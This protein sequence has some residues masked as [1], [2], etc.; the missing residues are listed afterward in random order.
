LRSE[1]WFLAAF[2]VWTLVRAANPDLWHPIY[3]GEK[4]F[5]FGFLNAILRSPVLPP[6][7]PFFSGGIVNYYYYG[8]FLVA[9]P[10]KAI[11]I[12]PAVGFNLAIALL[13]ALTTTAVLALGREISG[14]WRWGLLAV[15]FLVGMGPLASIIKINEARGLTPVFQAL[16]TGLTGF[17]ERLGAWFWGPSRIIPYTINE[18]PLFAFLFADLHPHLIALPITL[19]AVACALELGRRRPDAMLLALGA[20]VL[21]ALAV[22]NSWDAPTYALVIGGT[23]VGRTWQRAR[24]RLRTP[25]IL[26]QVGV[27]ALLSLGMLI[28]GVVLYFPFFSH[29]QAMVGGIGF[30]EQ[31][32]RVVDWLL[33]FGPLLFVAISLLGVL[34]WQAAYRA[35]VRWRWAARGV[36][37]FVPLLPVVL[38]LSGWIGQDSDTGVALP[39]LLGVL[40][41]AGAGMAPSLRLRLRDWLPLWLITVG[42]LVALGV[43]L[44]FV[45]DHLAGSDFRRMNT[46]FKFGFQIWTLLAL[47]S[48]TAVPLIARYLRRHET[49]FG[50]WLGLLGILLLPG[51]VYP[52][53]GIPSRLSTRFD[54]TQSLTLDGLAFMHQG[55]YQHEDRTISLQPDAEAIAWLN[56]NI[57]GTP[58]FLTSEK[59]FYRAYGMRVAAN[60]GLPTVL[61]KLHQDE[62]RDG[63]AV[64]ERERDVQTLFNTTDPALIQQ[65]LRKYR[66]EYVYIGPIERVLYAPEGIAKFAQL[67]GTLLEQVY[68]NDGVQIYRV[69]VD[70]LDSTTAQPQ[71]VPID[72]ET[73]ALETALAINPSDS[74]AAFALGRRYLEL[75]RADDA[76]R[77]MEA[78]IRAHPDDVPLRHLWGD[79][80]LRAGRADEAIA[81]WQHAVD[82]A[83]TP[84]NLAKLGRELIVLDRFDDAERTLNEATTID[85]NFGEALFFLGEL[86]RTRNSP[87]DRERAVA[88]YQLYLERTPADSPWR[89]QAAAALEEFKN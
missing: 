21:G 41:G 26:I 73:A 5:E 63:A 2:A 50:V 28:V 85:P 70:A 83:H 8:L 22:A 51:L 86:Y 15:F 10:M 7:D 57:K 35:D 1:L 42:L 71:V 55:Q 48:A 67:Q 66:V 46:V 72:S 30:V 16:D 38:L 56:K 31:G 34:L 59:E 69:D 12:D 14:R 75:D 27:A 17:G 9:L 68:A 6:Y 32:D 25:Q 60:T 74:G 23:L 52:L 4:P 49:A 39:L 19:V 43:Q 82:I 88:H 80:L 87:G 53:A 89:E 76:V 81:A 20:L 79:A 77:V 65:L 47:G 62:Q 61:G 84:N 13:F 36:A 11:G 18:F 78:A 45:R 54:T 58:V 24:G 64:A 3:G 29:Y 44:V 33:W 40:G 37:L